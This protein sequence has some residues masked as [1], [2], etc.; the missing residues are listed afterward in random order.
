M[1]EYLLVFL[2]AASVTYL[3]TVIAREIAQRT[4]AVAQV[5]DRDMHAVPIPYFGGL[6][7]L[8]GLVA[9]FLVARELPFM[10]T[11]NIIMRA[12]KAG[13]NRQELHERVRVHSLAAVKLMK[14]EGRAN[15][16]LDRMRADDMLGPHVTD[17][18]LDPA[19]YVGRAPQQVDEFLAELLEPLLAQHAHRRG[20]FAP[21]VRV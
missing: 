10:A 18:V 19:A 16:L 8:G 12:V 13:G 21:R 2:V 1:R 11:E 9:A 5:R 7:M 3:L 4:G 6:A 14:D 20:R 17:D 15:D